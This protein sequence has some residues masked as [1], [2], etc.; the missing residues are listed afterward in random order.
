M[1]DDI[2]NEIA[3]QIFITTLTVVGMVETAAVPQVSLGT[4]SMSNQ[5]EQQMHGLL[6][7]T[8]AASSHMCCLFNTL[9]PE[10]VHGAHDADS[11]CGADPL[12]MLICELWRR[13]SGC[14]SRR[15]PPASAVR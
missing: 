3:A 11:V 15:Q 13:A 2:D 10:H 4:I 12:R 8:S 1:P 5:A 14:C 9:W 7:N 6:Q